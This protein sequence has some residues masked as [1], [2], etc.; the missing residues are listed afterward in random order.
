MKRFTLIVALVL[1]VAMPTF[2]ERVTSE[3]AQK[4]ATTF[5]N[6]NGAKSAQLTD[7]SKEAGFP[8]LYIFNAEQ[9]FVVISAD[10]YV[11][12]ILGYSLT[13][14][15][16]AKNMPEN[17]KW[18][19]QGY[20]DE[21]QSAIDNK[22][23]ATNETA[24][25]WKD[26]AEGNSKAG[27]ATV[28]VAPLIQTKWNQNKYYN[29]LCPQVGDGIDGHAYTGCVA[30][31]MAQIMK[32]WEYPT[33][34]IRS[35]SYTWNNQTLSADF[36][37][38]TYDW[39]N[40]NDY[41]EYYFDDDGNYHS[42]STPT[43]VEITAVATLMYHCGVSVDMIYGGNSTGGSSATNYAVSTALTTY[44]NYS[45]TLE[46]KQKSHTDL[47][48]QTTTTY[49]TDAQWITMLK[50]E[51]NAQR[52]LQ[53]GGQDPNGPS[54]HAFV[55]DGYN[56][57]DYFHFN[58]GWAGAYNGYFSINNLNTGAN[59]QSGQG[60]GV[61]TRNQDA[62]FGIQPVQCAA[63][64]PTNLT[65]TLTGLQ[66]ITL[67]WTAANGAASYNIYRNNNYV[68]NSTTNSYSEDAPFGTNVYY[69]R[70]VDANGNL[71]LSSNTVTVYIG[72]QTPIVD[73]LEASL[74][75]NN[76][77]LSWTTPEW[78]Y[79]ETPSA[80]LTYGSGVLNSMNS[81]K[82]WAH[83]YLANDIAQYSGKTVYK[84]SFF[85]YE[86]GT[87]NCY[88]YKGTINKPNND[89]Q[90]QTMV[91]S[92][93]IEVMNTNIWMEIDLDNLVAIDGENDIWVVINY[94]DNGNGKYAATCTQYS[95]QNNNGN[96]R[97]GYTYSDGTI[98][99]IHNGDIAWL[100]KAYV[101]DGTYTY[102][103][104]RNG[105]TL[106]TNL[107][108]TSYNDQNRNNTA[109]FYTVKTNYYGGET[110]ASNGVGYALG[111]ASISTLALNV[112]DQMTITENSTLTVSGMLSDANADN[113]ILENGAQLIHNSTNVQAT[114]KK[115][116]T[117]YN[118]NPDNG[119]Y[120]IASPVTE[121]I[122][123][124]ASNGLLTNDYDLYKFDQSQELE[125]RNYKASS[126]STIDHKTGYLYANSGNPTLVFT[127]TLAA[128]AEPTNLAYI[129]DVE[130]S[131][132]NLIGNPYPCNAYIDR[133]FYVL[134]ADTAEFILGSNPIPPCAA[135]LV[136]AQGSGESVTF[137]KT[138]SKSE[139]NISISVAANTRGNAI[140]DQARVSFNENDQLM[141]YT[142]S[143]QSSKLYIPQNGQ[144]FAVAFAAN[145][146][147][148]PVNLK[149]TK[150]GTYTICVEVENLELDY[151]H[152]IDNKTGADVDLL[153]T[154]NYTFEAKTTDYESRFKLVFNENNDLSTGSE[155]FAYV[156]NGEIVIT[157]T[158]P[159]ASL[160]IVDITGRIIVSRDNVHTVSTIGMTP[161]VYVLRLINNEKVKTQKI[162]I[163]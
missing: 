49:Y 56:S 63:S 88:V 51:L 120:L 152:L 70:S 38:T 139:P 158:C 28:T 134:N 40:M 102:N 126:F 109:S 159:S 45:P 148:M 44:F 114:V 1:M 108:T 132:F 105:A 7:L 43:S 89:F 76:V 3:T 98:S 8:N 145:Q 155:A 153:T 20:S 128:S 52:P 137:S 75:E 144:D 90:P 79:P 12:P 130:F 140:I 23:S 72:Y 4:V 149:A 93:T 65:Y 95:G 106:A 62:I 135:I 29:N 87:Y 26:L 80:T 39:D 77:N 69:V 116:I 86:T 127:G 34:G 160:Q 15:F 121:S 5:L 57:S 146:T 17:L 59:N 81:T 37:A 157:E 47:Q 154:P 30:T 35:H 68:G 131:G 32:Y 112:N 10:D 117:S 142:L 110:A 115:D 84:I 58:W 119:W 113:L 22:M 13:N 118:E 100:I 36:G 156:N 91:T 107:T 129:T 2:A 48:T 97:H 9:G 53:Y 147:E 151:L 82:Y 92:K 124:S 19:L 141:K 162:V 83:R 41:Y 42:L 64:E 60:N 125:W 66:D 94:P 96:Y 122:T 163:K 101:T 14:K 21:I 123:P 143:D 67:N 136:Q 54:G 6:N 138:A 74:S 61:Y 31:A 73:D 71:S 11:Q 103:L 133:S 33:H 85:I 46:Y 78:C 27:K 16:D 18:W 24:K 50:A 161:G 150:N 99:F 55:C 104:Y 111:Q 25:M